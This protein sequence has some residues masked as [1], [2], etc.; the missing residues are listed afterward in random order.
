MTSRWRSAPYMRSGTTITTNGLLPPTSHSP[1]LTQ[2]SVRSVET[3]TSSYWTAATSASPRAD[4]AAS[5]AR[6][7]GIEPGYGLAT[8]ISRV[9]RSGR[10][11]HSSIAICRFGT[12]RRG[13]VSLSTVSPEG[14]A[15]RCSSRITESLGP[16]G[17]RGASEFTFSRK[18]TKV[19]ANRPTSIGSSA[20]RRWYLGRSSRQ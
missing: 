7:G 6:R 16:E 14:G 1:S 9:G 4:A 15:P 8:P 18:V 11:V 2:G 13:T 10:L 17:L 5:S 12:S 20:I 3:S 19:R